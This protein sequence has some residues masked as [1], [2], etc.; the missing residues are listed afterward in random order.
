MLMAKTGNRLFV[1]GAILAICG[2]MANAVE[3]EDSL[4]S[5]IR[6][7]RAERKPIM[8]LGT[9]PT[10]G[11]CQ[12]MKAEL[13]NPLLSAS[14]TDYVG[15]VVEAH[16][17]DFQALARH[18]GIV[19]NSVPATILVS[20]D[21]DLLHLQSGG[22]SAEQ[23]ASL[24]AETSR[25]IGPRLSIAQR[26]KIH[27]I[28]GQ[29]REAAAAGELVDALRLITP[30][31]KL[32]IRDPSV[33][34][35]QDYRDQLIGAIDGWLTRLNE[36]MAL[37]QNRYAAAFH[38]ANITR[39]LPKDYVHLRSH[40]NAILKRYAGTDGSSLAVRQASLL[41]L[42]REKEAA[43]RCQ[44]AL[45]LYRELE[46]LGPESPTG[47]LANR[48]MRVVQQ[49]QSAKLTRIGGGTMRGARAAH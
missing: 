13:Q 10:C 1:A 32:S 49:K 38:L 47:K 9:L 48:R 12:V 25:R 8:I 30:C 39:H 2:A 46:A 43:H 35:S 14:W 20:P 19:V 4:R 45:A 29:V 21:G 34:K 3:L 18:F 17:E 31:A 36:D 44:D 33:A 41:V 6:N 27:A 26:H 24:L 40:A 28:Q 15:V 23:L 11:P 16:S 22:M 5:A 37:Q 7:A 42:A